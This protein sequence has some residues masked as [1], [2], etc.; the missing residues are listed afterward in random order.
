MLNICNIFALSNKTIV[1]DMATT[2]NIIETALQ[3]M[4]RHDWYWCMA[5]YTNP[6]YGNAYSSMRTFVELVASIEDCTIVKALRDLWTAHYEF[7]RASMFGSNDEAKSQFLEKK[8][9]L[10]SIIM[11]NYA[12]AA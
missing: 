12:V 11:P 7:T 5:D 10:M 2:T 9:K 1:K 4:N 6:A 3:V 8:T